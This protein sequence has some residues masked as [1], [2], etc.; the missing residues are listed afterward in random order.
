LT[1]DK[2]DG[3]GPVVHEALQQLF[4]KEILFVLLMQDPENPKRTIMAANVS[5]D[6][7][8]GLIK[9]MAEGKGSPVFER[10]VTV[11]GGPE[12]AQ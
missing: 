6:N 1:N 4:G 9:V 11:K 2:L 5:T 10:T 12:R 3:V 8:L 7:A